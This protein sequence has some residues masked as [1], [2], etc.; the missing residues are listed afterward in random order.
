MAQQEIMDGVTTDTRIYGYEGRTFTDDLFDGQTYTMEL[1]QTGPYNGRSAQPR[2]IMLY[3]LSE[4]YYHYLTGI[5]N[6]DDESFNSDLVDW[7]FSEPNAYYSQW[8]NRDCRRSPVFGLYGRFGE[9]DACRLGEA[10][11][12]LPALYDGFP[13]G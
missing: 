5:L 9:R 2:R 11:F 1:V 3:S 13:S 7:G 12:F 4:A 10:C 8:R 6:V